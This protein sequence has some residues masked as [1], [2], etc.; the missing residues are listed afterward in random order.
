MESYPITLE[1]YDLEAWARDATQALQRPVSFDRGEVVIG[2][3]S[4]VAIFFHDATTDAWLSP[5]YSTAAGDMHFVSEDTEEFKVACYH[6]WAVDPPPDLPPDT[7]PC[8]CD[9][10]NARADPLAYLESMYSATDWGDWPW[11]EYAEIPVIY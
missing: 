9:M 10:D 5:Y 11:Q 3:G 8:P 7:W 6:H 1:E 2:R 4:G